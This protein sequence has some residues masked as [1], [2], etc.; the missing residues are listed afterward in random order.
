MASALVRTVAVQPT[1]ELDLQLALEV[2]YVGSDIPGGTAGANIS[3]IFP[4]DAQPA[5]IRSAISNAV[6][7]EAANQGFACAGA[8]MSIPVFQKG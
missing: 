8:N 7:V 3:C 4:G 1:A 2:I 6:S 5:Q